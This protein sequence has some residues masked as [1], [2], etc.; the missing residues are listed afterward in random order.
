MTAT[1]QA[2]AAAELSAVLRPSLL[3]LTRTIRNQRVDTSVTLTLLTALFN[4]QINGPMTPGELAVAERVQPPSM[5]RILAGLEAKGL[6]RRDKHPT[7][8]RQVIVSVTPQ[9]T[10]LLAREREAREAW[11]ARSLKQLTPTELQL[12][13]AVQ[14]LLDKIANL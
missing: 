2:N 5:T 7:D 13:R 4:L 12:L 8:G 1:R 9:G 10:A 14:P 11:L 3:R 6:A